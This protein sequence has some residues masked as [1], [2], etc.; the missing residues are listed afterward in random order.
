MTIRLNSYEPL[1]LFGEREYIIEERKIP[2]YV[3]RSPRREP[4]FESLFPSIT[5][6]CRGPRY[7]GSLRTGD[8][9]IYRT[10]MADY[11]HFGQA[12][13]RIVAILQVMDIFQSHE[14]AA[15]WYKEHNID[16]PSNC[17]I[18]GNMPKPIEECKPLEKTKNKLNSLFQWDAQYRDRAKKCSLFAVC[19]PLF[20]ELS[21]PPIHTMANEMEV[22][23]KRKG[24]RMPAI[25]TEL[26]FNKLL[27]I[28]K[29][30]LK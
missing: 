2:P 10:N 25:I 12:H 8:I 21:K 16:V 24:T 27:S 5:S 1:I 3:D 26:E 23:G 20:V 14:K 30:R 19:N 6:L 29:I 11:E 7:I 22:F 17:M 9:V 13:W 28:N 4:D 15:Q 18:A